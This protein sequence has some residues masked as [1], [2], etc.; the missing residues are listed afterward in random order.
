MNTN[1]DYLFDLRGYLV[2]EGALSAAEVAA[3]NGSIDAF[4]NLR[5]PGQAINIHAGGASRT[6]RNQF[7]YH[8]G[9]FSCGQINILVALTDIG[10]GDGGPMIV[11]GSHKSNLPHPAFETA[12]GELMGTAMDN[13]LEAVEV[14]MKAGDALLFVDCLC[15]GSAAR[16][17]PGERRIL[18][19]RYGPSWGNT[20]FGYQPSEELLRR[21]TAARRKIVQPIT[22][23]RPERESG[24][25]AG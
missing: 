6:I 2:L 14:P 5:G 4:V 25:I 13:T 9:E 8:D 23:R 3:I 18:V 20:R 17:N 22:P 11:P 7:R 24:E 16:A 10:A 21:L 1:D 12:Y 15:H 19:Y